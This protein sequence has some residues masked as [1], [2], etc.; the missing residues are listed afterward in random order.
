M[1]YLQTYGKVKKQIEESKRKH[2]LLV[3]KK[4]DDL[5]SAIL[6]DLQRVVKSRKLKIF[7]VKAESFE[8]SNGQPGAEL[9]IY[10]RME[11]LSKFYFE[12]S[13]VRAGY[14]YDRK[15]VTLDDYSEFLSDFNRIITRALFSS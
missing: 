5:R 2:K 13:R 7:S 12:V 11:S 1:K 8:F 3:Q 6:S 9:Q 15:Q 14:A 10:I 4:G